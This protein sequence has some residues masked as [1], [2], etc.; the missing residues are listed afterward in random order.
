M[1]TMWESN[2]INSRSGG[3]ARTGKHL[4]DKGPAKEIHRED[5][6]GE[7]NTRNILYII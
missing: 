1:T 5:A 3:E 6:N 2:P 7:K 4:K